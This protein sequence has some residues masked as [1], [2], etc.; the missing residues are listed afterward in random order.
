MHLISMINLESVH[1]FFFKRKAIYYLIGTFL[2][3]ALKIPIEKFL[4]K[5]FV[6]PILSNVQPAWSLDVFVITIALCIILLTVSR[7][8]KYVASTKFLFLEILILGVYLYY[9]YNETPWTFISFYWMDG[10]NYA[11][12]LILGIFC[13]AV[14]LIPYK[15]V[16]QKNIPGSLFE[17]KPLGKKGKDILGYSSYAELLGNKILNSHFDK[18]F[19]IGINGK[20]GLGKTSFIDLLKRT[21]KAPDI[22]EIDF[23]PWNSQSP[24]A[25]IQDFFDSFNEKVRPYHSSIVRLSNE[26]AA[27]LVQLK[28]NTLTKS[29][30]L[31]TS[32]LTNNK[33][34]NSLYHQINK[35]LEEINKKV[36]VY[37]DDLDRLD[38]HEIVEVLRLIRNTANFYNTIFVVAYDRNYI[39]NALNKHT[40][41]GEIEFLEKIFQLEVTLPN[42]NKNILREE[43]AEKLKKSFPKA[44]PETFD[45]AIVGKAN[46]QPTYLNEWLETMRDVTRLTNNITI[47]Y[48]KLVDEII[49]YDFLQL[50]LIRLKY[51]SVYE[52]LFRRRSDFL[53]TKYNQ[54]TGTNQYEL[55]KDKKGVILENYLKNNY[56]NLSIPESNITKMSSL[57]SGIF[58]EPDMFGFNTKEHLS[59]IHPSKFDRYFSYTLL[60][61]DL[62]EIEFSNARDL[63]HN[64]FLTKITEWTKLGLAVELKNRFYEIN[65]FDS[66]EDF[67]KIIRAIFHLAIFPI[68]NT[69][70][71]FVNIVNFDSKNLL[72]KLDNYEDSIVKKYYPKED[73]KNQLE[74]FI[75][76]LFANAPSPYT[77]EAQI[78]NRI[79]TSYQ[80]IYPISEKLSHELVISYLKKY[81]HE[82]ATLDGHIWNLFHKCKY[83][84]HNDINSNNIIPQEAKETV[85]NFFLNKDLDGFLE[86]IVDQNSFDNGIYSLSTMIEVIFDTWTNF[87][88]E[89]NK[90]DESQYKNL[91]EFN[92]FYKLFSS[93]NHSQGVA[94][95][96]KNIKVKQSE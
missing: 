51:P 38:S 55:G 20:W 92:R 33:P 76:S 18:S 21:V 31:I 47:N 1:K 84:E 59:V 74:K 10:I 14:L 81:C 89:L 11:D 23:N 95:E 26:Y 79:N 65:T 63:D 24:Q 27:K 7:F 6:T 30:Q 86:A 19:A 82:T 4:S 66:R 12:L 37:I 87:E 5:N 42:F 62:S 46:S 25:I 35:A 41:F 40:S 9:R 52:L 36:V 90:K 75:E 83:K 85:K 78:L 68:R 34:T 49:F 72:K 54:R 71:V 50:E 28:P 32:S 61:G 58:P 60:Q 94:F 70:M 16:K 43:L 39:V 3:V 8:K 88:N 29:I 53:I 67:E 96:F 17:D 64:K 91:E 48:S 57:I 56:K 77:F 2:L 22:I 93:S 13:Q 80:N 69:N 45:H 15:K 44:K 73:G